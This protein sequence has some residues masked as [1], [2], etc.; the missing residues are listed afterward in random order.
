MRAVWILV[1]LA[2][3]A[4]SGQAGAA[5]APLP[6]R[7]PPAT[8]APIAI[9]PPDELRAAVAE[10]RNRPELPRLADPGFLDPPREAELAWI[11]D[12]TSPLDQR[13]KLAMALYDDTKAIAKRYV[14]FDRARD[15]TE[16]LRW[17]ESTIRQFGHL[18]SAM[19]DEFLP[20]LSPTDPSYAQRLEGLEGMRLGAAGMLQGAL[21]TL[22]AQRSELPERRQL[23]A[24]WR[25]HAP[26][27]ARLWRQAQCD[28]LAASL[29]EV[30]A[31]QTD[32]VIRQELTETAAA[33]AACTGARSP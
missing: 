31:S 16:G 10:Y 1:L 24:A 33:M 22:R 12:R 14:P 21:I 32:R 5:S 23:A 15:S 13:L 2:G 4:S 18:T 9:R 11:D 26:R 7:I 17:I 6:Q 19:V 30:A 20:G 8:A 3:C 29:R 25:E 27:F 28:Q